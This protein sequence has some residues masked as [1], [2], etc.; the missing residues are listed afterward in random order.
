MQQASLK[1]FNLS[2]PLQLRRIR[3]PAIKALELLQLVSHPRTECPHH[4]RLNI[5][6]FQ[7]FCR[8]TTKQRKEGHATDTTPPHLIKIPLIPLGS[9]IGAILARSQPHTTRRDSPK[10]RFSDSLFFRLSNVDF[11]SLLRI[12][13]HNRLVPLPHAGHLHI[14][15][16]LQHPS[17]F[18]RNPNRTVRRPRFRREHIAVNIRILSAHRFIAQILARLSMPCL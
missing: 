7:T 3:F 13:K 1:H 16:S 18:L 4:E 8:R 15:F 6:V 11:F 12:L 14:H 9:R 5:P 2:R 10:T 17:I